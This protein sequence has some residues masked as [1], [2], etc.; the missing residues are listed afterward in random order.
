M[1]N[2]LK[3]LL[4]EKNGLVR[5]AESY[6]PDI[7][8]QAERLA[9]Q[10]TESLDRGLTRALTDYLGR[11]PTTTEIRSYALR[12]VYADSDIE[13]FFWGDRHLL[14]I[15]PLRLFIDADGALKAERKV[16]KVGDI[17]KESQ[18][19]IEIRSVN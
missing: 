16:Q 10:A 18:R 19:P 9:K 5:A 8:D 2:I 4:V 1:V 14:R 6:G 17:R 13:E 15:Y 12:K 11:A 7:E 3:P